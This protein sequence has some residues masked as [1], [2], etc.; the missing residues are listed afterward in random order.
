MEK[1][2]LPEKPDVLFTHWPMDIHQDHQISGLPGFNAWTKS[3]RQ[4]Q[5]Y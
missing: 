5:L 3:G 2:I 4:F 1:L